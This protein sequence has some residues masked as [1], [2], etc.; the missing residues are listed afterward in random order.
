MHKNYFLTYKITSRLSEST[1]YKRSVSFM[2]RFL[3]HSKLLMYLCEIPKSKTTNNKK[4]KTQQPKTNKQV[5]TLKY[6]Q[7]LSKTRLCPTK[8]THASWP[9]LQVTAFLYYLTLLTS[10]YLCTQTWSVGT[11]LTELIPKG[12]EPS[13]TFHQETPVEAFQSPESGWTCGTPSSVWQVSGSVLKPSGILMEYFQGTS[14]RASTFEY[15]FSC[16]QRL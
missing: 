7:A 12:P 8:K 13:V 6:F 14:R 3:S 5:W 9:S 4:K 1:R 15:A 16:L 10:V 2:F 11:R